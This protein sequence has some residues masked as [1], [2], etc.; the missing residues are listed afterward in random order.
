MKLTYIDWI[1]RIRGSVPIPAGQAEAFEALDPLFRQVGTRHTLSGDTLTFTKKD[2]AAQD[3]MSVFD[4]GELRIDRAGAAPV[5]RF[6]LSS[7]ALLFCF[8]APLLF[9]GIGQATVVVAKYDKPPQESPKKPVVHPMNPVDKFLHAPAPDP[10]K[11]PGAD[12]DK[13]DKKL[14]P[15]AAYVFA[16]IFLALYVIGRILEDWLFRRLLRRAL[17]GDLDVSQLPGLPQSASGGA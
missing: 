14:T 4:S 7:R 13:K 10:E 6:S 15:T 17:A 12:K 1:W 8:L 9:L 2:Q 3:P 11:K 16:G 5:L